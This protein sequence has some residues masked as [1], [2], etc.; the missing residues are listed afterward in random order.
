M[1]GR[2]YSSSNVLDLN[3]FEL[4]DWWEEVPQENPLPQQLSKNMIK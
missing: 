4:A 3:S 1:G 2:S